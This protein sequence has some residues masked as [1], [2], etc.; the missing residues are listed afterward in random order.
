MAMV[1]GVG[2]AAGVVVKVK[3]GLH[4]SLPAGPP[5]TR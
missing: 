2:P 4:C 5:P 3:T 1:T